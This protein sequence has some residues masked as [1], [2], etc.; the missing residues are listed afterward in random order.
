[1][2]V[3]VRVRV[4]VS[5]S[6]TVMVEAARWGSGAVILLAQSRLIVVGILSGRRAR[7]RDEKAAACSRWGEGQAG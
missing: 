3:R 1:M 2:S 4:S 5:V 7:R 6:D